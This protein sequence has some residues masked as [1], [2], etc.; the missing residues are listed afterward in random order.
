MRR[1]MQRL[2]LLIFFL[3]AAGVAVYFVARL[4]K[5]SVGESKQPAEGYLLQDEHELAGRDDYSGPP[6]KDYLQRCDPLVINGW[7][8]LDGVHKGFF[9]R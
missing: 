9:D 4:D 6:K 1:F 7:R 8:Y 3:A 2:L 5:T